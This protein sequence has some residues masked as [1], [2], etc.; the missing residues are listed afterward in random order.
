MKLVE[1]KEY[2]I[3]HKVPIMSD[4]SLDF[5]SSI[6]KE[7]NSRSLLEIGTAIAYSSLYIQDK[8]PD[9]L[10]DTLEKDQERYEVA[11]QNLKEIEFSHNITSIQ[12]NA[13]K[14][15][16]RKSYD[17]IVIDAA[18]AQNETLFRL[19]FAFCNKVMI[20]D[21]VDFH[22]FT[23]HSQEIKKRNLR[24]LVSRIERFLTYLDT[25]KDIVVEKVNIGDGI[26]VIKRKD[27]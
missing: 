23:G 18:K 6:L 7:T 14:Y 2:A 8:I 16:N 21:N 9:L 25:R 10:I 13:L 11:K 15:D 5:I 24:Q 12:T 19:Y 4:E 17:A 1:I 3:E 27:L 22:G 26:L 20:V